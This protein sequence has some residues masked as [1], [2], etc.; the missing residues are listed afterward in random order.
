MNSNTNYLTINQIE[1]Q[2]IKVKKS[3]GINH[4]YNKA[5]VLVAGE[6][7]LSLINHFSIIKID[8]KITNN[9]YTIFLKKK[10]FISEVLVLRLS[11]YRYLIIT[12]NLK[13][14]YRLL[15]RK[16]RKYPLTVISNVT[17]E[18]ST[19]SFHGDNAD[20]FFK[21]IDYRY[22]FK[23]QH[24]GY[25]YYQLICPKKE[26]EITFKHFLKLNFIPISLDV[27]KLFLYNNNVVTNISKIPKPYKL[28]VCAEIYPNNTLKY[29]L[30]EITVH[31]Y[32]L[33]GNFL[34]TNKH[35]IY[36]YLR[37][38]A[39]IIHCTYRLPKQPYPIVLA[40]VEKSKIRKVS[41]IKVGRKK[42]AIIRPIFNY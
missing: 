12:D 41:L 33:E 2:Y 16:R 6:M 25:T 1:E 18:Y 27:K 30:K 26:R 37:K 34:V 22:I 36:S 9:F 38:K 35:K 24:Q 28:S 15:K 3:I 10:K 20:S 23:T 29:K 19:F 42:D 11:L 8:E 31:K 13:G 39:G 4:D 40:F 7:A 17:N 5:K 14:V 21:D 32:E